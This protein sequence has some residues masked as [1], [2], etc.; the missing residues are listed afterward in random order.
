M[1]AFFL[2][3]NRMK[4]LILMF[5]FQWSTLSSQSG[6]LGITAHYNYQFLAGD[7]ES[8]YTGNSNVGLGLSLKLKSNWTIGTEGQ[9]LFGSSS[10]DLKLLGSIATTGGFVIGQGQSI[11][12]PQLEGRGANF[13]IDFGKIVPLNKKNLNSGLHIKLGFGYQYYKAYLKTDDILVTQISGDYASGYENQESGL[14]INNFI[15]Y[16]YFSKNK[17]LNGSFGLNTVYFTS[18]YDGVWNFAENKAINP[19]NFS[20]FLIGPKLNIFIIFRTLGN[21]APQDGFYYK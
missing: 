21:K 13:Q 6:Y 1:A 19:S 18:K 4:Y 14:T 16:T 17:L 8:K 11:E 5:L 20:S 3:S 10:K 15:G 9:F 2:N 12:T 7:L